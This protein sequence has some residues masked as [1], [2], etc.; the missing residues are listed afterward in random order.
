MIDEIE[1]SG[2]IE[3]VYNTF[4][5]T[6]PAQMTDPDFIDVRTLSGTPGQAG[7]QVAW[8]WIHA[9]ASL[10]MIETILECDRPHR[11]ASAISYSRYLPLPEEHR[12]PNEFITVGDD[13]DNLFRINF[14]KNP[15]EGVVLVEFSDIELDRTR[16]THTFEISVGGFSRFFGFFAA[17]KKNSPAMVKLKN[18][19]DTFEADKFQP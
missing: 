10:E 4:V 6:D 5:R 7:F 2:P 9:R 18:F 16:I 14:G 19:R 17:R 12:K 13:L 1:I 8:Y 11:I 3:Q 15:V